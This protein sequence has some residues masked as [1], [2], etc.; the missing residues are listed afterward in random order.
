MRVAFAAVLVLAAVVAVSPAPASGPRACYGG[1]LSARAGLQGAGGAMEGGV[2]VRNRSTHT[3]V[4]SGR[5]NVDFL[6]GDTPLRPNVLPGPSTTGVRR[7]R[8]LR[9]R[10][11]AKAFVHLRW[12]NWCGP[13]SPRVGVRLWLMSVKP[14]LPVSGTTGMPRCDNRERPSVVAVGPWEHR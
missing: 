14:R 12:S 11:G 7:T 8:A 4:L 2:T 9:L 1:D 5:P 10:P 3:C 13:R 6:N